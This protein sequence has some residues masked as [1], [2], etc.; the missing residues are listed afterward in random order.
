MLDATP[1]ASLIQPGLACMESWRNLHQ[2]SARADSILYP[3]CWS[4]GRSLIFSWRRSSQ[5]HPQLM[6]FH[7]STRFMHCIFDQHMPA[8]W[9]DQPRDP[10][11]SP[12][13]INTF[14]EKYDIR[15]R[16]A[17]TLFHYPSQLLLH[18][19]F[20]FFAF[21]VRTM[22]ERVVKD[23]ER[24]IFQSEQEKGCG[25]VRPSDGGGAF[26]FETEDVQ[27]RFFATQNPARTAKIA[28]RMVGKCN[29]L[30]LNLLFKLSVNKSIWIVLYENARR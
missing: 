25:A 21:A 8:E 24:L 29:L 11:Q 1:C 9:L 18:H 6:C 12:R 14:Q 17:S 22:F 30:T 13:L 27:V 19:D 7:V 26:L 28:G 3:T 23:H 16:M 5:C 2:S 20:S 15:M 4:S 10:V